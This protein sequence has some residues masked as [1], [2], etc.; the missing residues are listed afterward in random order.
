MTKIDAVPT[1]RHFAAVGYARAS[2]A[3]R[4]RSAANLPV[5]ELRLVFLVGIYSV[6]TQW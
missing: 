4:A 2:P 6:S 1:A 5:T 3:T